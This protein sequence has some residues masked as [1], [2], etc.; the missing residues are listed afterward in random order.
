M[1]DDSTP[2]AARRFPR[3]ALRDLLY[4]LCWLAT[5]RRGAAIRVILAYG[6]IGDDPPGGIPETELAWQMDHLRTCF[7]VV[8]LRELVA[9]AQEYRDAPLACIT[10]DGGR[11]DAFERALPV[12]EKR[13]LKATFF[14]PSGSVGVA[15]PDRAPGMGVRELRQLARLG[16]EIGAQTVTGRSLPELDREE[17]TEEIEGSKRAL[18]ELLGAPVPCFAYPDGRCSP[19]V[20]DLVGEAA[21]EA[22]VTLDEGLVGE[23][24]DPLALPRVRVRPSTSRVAFRARLSSAGTLYERLRGRG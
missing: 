12:L 7:R 11:L 23:L 5:R 9:A 3:D 10:F 24:T 20:R 13:S 14:V 1:D 4:G 8:P 15:A 2:T 6:A 17:A 21:F 18:E 16:H 22:A 19:A